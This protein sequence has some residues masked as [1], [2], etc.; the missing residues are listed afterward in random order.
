MSDA[1]ERYGQTRV[2]KIKAAYD[3]L[4]GAVRSGDMEAAERALDRYEQW[5]DVVFQPSEAAARIEAL[6]AQVQELAEYERRILEA[7]E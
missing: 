4:R 7:L 5:A 2:S 3:D 1:P 6:Q